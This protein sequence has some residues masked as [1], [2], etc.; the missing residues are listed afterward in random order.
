MNSIAC[1]ETVNLLQKRWKPRLV[2]I[3]CDFLIIYNGLETYNWLSPVT[4]LIFL[5]EG[6][7]RCSLN[8]NRLTSSVIQ[9][10]YKVEKVGFSQVRW[11]LFLKMSPSKSRSNSEKSETYVGQGKVDCICFPNTW[12]AYFILKCKNYKRYIIR[13]NHGM[14]ILFICSNCLNYCC[15]LFSGIRILTPFNISSFACEQ[16]NFYKHKKT[17]VLTHT[18]VGPCGCHLSNINYI[19]SPL[20]IL[21]ENTNNYNNIPPFESC[22]SIGRYN[23]CC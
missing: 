11:W 23:C 1:A 2:L 3:T 9:C 16:K 7:K 15:P 5:N 18:E 13:R 4:Y 14:H 10:D 22:A 19:N 12:A 20:Q 6:N 17:Y 8:F 21:V